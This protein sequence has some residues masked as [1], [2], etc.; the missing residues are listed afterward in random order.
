M[1]RRLIVYIIKRQLIR[2][3]FSFTW[4]WCIMAPV[5]WFLFAEL[6]HPGYIKDTAIG[7]DQWGNTLTFGEPGETISSRLG[8]G[9]ENGNWTTAPP[10]WFLDQFDKG[11]CAKAWQANPTNPSPGAAAPAQ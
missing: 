10:C 8:R 9:Q 1:I 11:H 3:L 5:V 7:F 2:K 4:R 6:V